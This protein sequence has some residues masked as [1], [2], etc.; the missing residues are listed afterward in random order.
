MK[1]HIFDPK[2]GLDYELVGDHYLIADDED[3]PPRPIG[4]WGQRRLQHLKTHRPSLYDSLL[5]SNRLNDHLADLN[6]AA[7]AMAARL[8][9]E[10]AQREGVDE[11][12]K[13][14]DPLSWVG[15]MNSIRARVREVVTNELIYT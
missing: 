5:L 15:R 10:L 9:R 1:S 14:A 7:T 4:L 12:L 6:E 8:V 3:P 2:T 13:A 11:R